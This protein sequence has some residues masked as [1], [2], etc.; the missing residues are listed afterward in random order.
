MDGYNPYAPPQRDPLAPQGGG[1]PAG[2]PQ[3]W[4]IGEVLTVGVDAVKKNPLELIGGYFVM[5][6]LSAIPGQLPN[7]LQLLG[8][9]SQNSALFWVL[10]V[11][12][13]LAGMLAGAFLWAGGLRVALAAARKEPIDF[14]TFFSG[15][16]RMVPLFILHLLMWLA[17]SFGIALLV[18]PGVVLSLGWALSS[19]L[20]VDAEE[21]PIEA[22]KASWELTQGHKM[23]L[24]LFALASMLI[25][26]AGVCACYIGLFVAVP[27]ISIAFAEVY[28]RVSGRM[29]GESAEAGAVAVY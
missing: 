17:V 4:E 25:A 15:G 21:S 16:D 10:F 22:L 8:V 24:F 3:P 29:G 2:Q 11:I 14:A 12:S 6:L 7:V 28:R 20:V 9:I 18:V 13:L 5:V 19:F 1:A 23:K 26:I 27:V